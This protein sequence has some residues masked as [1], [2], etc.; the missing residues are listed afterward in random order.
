MKQNTKELCY[1]GICT[2]LIAVCSWIVIPTG[3]APFTMQ[4]F[5]VFFT[6][7]FLGGKGGLYAVTAYLLLGALGAPVFAGFSGGLGV[8]LGSTGGY[9]LGFFAIVAVYWL[10]KGGEQKL[11]SLMLMILGLFLCYLLGTMQFVAIY[12]ANMGEGGFW[13]AMTWCVFPYVI[14]DLLKL[15]LAQQVAERVGKALGRNLFQKVPLG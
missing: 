3:T 13:T 7:F 2:A 11:W 6:L 14:P 4:T 1:S 12:A 10:G 5:A 8:L 9:L 15:Y